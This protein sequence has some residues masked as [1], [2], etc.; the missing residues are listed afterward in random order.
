MLTH[1][2]W[3]KLRQ[4]HLNRRNTAEI[5]QPISDM[6]SNASVIGERRSAS[7]S[8]TRRCATWRPPTATSTSTDPVLAVGV[9]LW[10]SLVR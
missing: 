3:N 10:S 7:S 2:K 4:T 8:F 1:L 9:S 6:A 5:I